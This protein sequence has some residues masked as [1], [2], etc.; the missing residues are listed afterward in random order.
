[1]GAFGSAAELRSITGGGVM[2]GT[3]QYLL[4]F[5]LKRVLQLRNSNNIIWSKGF[6]SGALACG[7]V[8]QLF[9]ALFVGVVPRVSRLLAALTGVRA[10]CVERSKDDLLGRRWQGGCA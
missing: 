2:E 6:R 10:F 7:G 5:H 1:M 8:T 3:A 9:V 4:I